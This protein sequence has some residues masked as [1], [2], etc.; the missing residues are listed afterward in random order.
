[1]FEA[2]AAKD[3]LNQYDFGHPDVTWEEHAL[4][5]VEEARARSTLDALESVNSEDSSNERLVQMDNMYKHQA[6]IH[7]ESLREPTSAQKKG[8]GKI[9]SRERTEKQHRIN[10]T[11]RYQSSHAFQ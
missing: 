10:V 3:I 6:M 7:L 5:F 4:L 8:T 1:V 2:G 9:A 11:A